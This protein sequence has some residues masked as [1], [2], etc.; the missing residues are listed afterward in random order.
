M[1]KYIVYQNEIEWAV[2]PKVAARCSRRC[3]TIDERDIDL[4]KRIRFGKAQPLI[5]YVN[6]HGRS[7][8]VRQFDRKGAIGAT[9]VQDPEALQIESQLFCQKIDRGSRPVATADLKREL[10]SELSEKR[11]RVAYSLRLCES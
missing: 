8:T 4:S 1:L 10:L 6:S 9:D 7:A 5:A 11:I 3:I 2:L